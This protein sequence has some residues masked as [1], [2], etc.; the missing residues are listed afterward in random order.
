MNSCLMY[1]LPRVGL[2]PGVKYRTHQRNKECGHWFSYPTRFKFASCSMAPGSFRVLARVGFDQGLRMDRPKQGRYFS[3][4][5]DG[6]C[7]ISSSSVSYTL[8]L[9]TPE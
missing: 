6:P 7:R 3:P 9:G 5:F 1:E 2:V 4:K 8:F